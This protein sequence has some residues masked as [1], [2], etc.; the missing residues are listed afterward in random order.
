MQTAT[1]TANVYK[2]NFNQNQEQKEQNKNIQNIIIAEEFIKTLKSKHTII[3]YTTALKTFFLVD[4]IKNINWKK[5]KDI[6]MLNIQT[7]IINL[8]NKNIAKQTI[9]SRIAALRTFYDYLYTLDKNIENPFRNNYISKIINNNTTKN[10][11]PTGIALTE[12][13]VSQLLNSITLPADYL[14]F[15]VLFTTGIRRSE[16]INIRWNDFKWNETY[17]RWELWVLGKGRKYRQLQIKDSLIE[18]LKNEFEWKYGNIGTTDK[19]VF[20]MTA[21]NINKKLSKY[22]TNIGI[23]M[24]PHDCRRTNI[25]ILWNNGCPTQTIANFAGHSTVKQT[26]KYVREYQNQKYNAGAFV[27]EF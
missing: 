24:T 17:K 9:R 5:V 15:K 25:T 2:V 14:L 27:P 13:Q 6:N 26:E 18:E 4:E 23:K 21:S 11:E 19:K 3:A 22:C 20:P 8:G 7:Y 12:E 16:A 10:N 1:Q